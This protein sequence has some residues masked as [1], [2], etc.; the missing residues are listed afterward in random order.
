MT[1][2]LEMGRISVSEQ[3]YGGQYLEERIDRLLRFSLENTWVYMSLTPLAITED[4]INPKDERIVATV[5]ATALA[6]QLTINPV[7]NSSHTRP[8]EFG[9]VNEDFRRLTDGMGHHLEVYRNGYLEIMVCLERQSRLMAQFA[10]EHGLQ[11]GGSH[12]LLHF[13]HLRFC[14]Q[15]EAS[16]VTSI[17]KTGLPFYNMVFSSVLTGTENSVIVYDPRPRW[18]DGFSYPVKSKYLRF[19]RVVDRDIGAEDLLYWPLERFVE[20]YGLVLPELFDKDGNPRQPEEF[21]A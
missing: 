3:V 4:A 10:K 7:V 16:F 9:L 20:S 18:A 15:S 14:L 17:W 5:N 2:Q 12:K 6:G 13:N 19:E 8:S 21:R 1:A 11:S